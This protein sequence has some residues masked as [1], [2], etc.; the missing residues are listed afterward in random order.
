[1]LLFQKFLIT[2]YS[3]I[4]FDIGLRERDFSNPLCGIRTRKQLERKERQVKICNF[5]FLFFPPNMLLTFVC[6][7]V[8]ARIFLNY[9][10]SLYW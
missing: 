10:N 7:V 8:Y 1:M 4:H 3:I 5:F 9:Y 2:M 6:P